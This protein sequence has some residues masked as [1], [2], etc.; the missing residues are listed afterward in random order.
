MSRPVTIFDIGDLSDTVKI[1]GHSVSVRGLSLSDILRLFVKYPSIYEMFSRSR[2][3][4][5]DDDSSA[6]RRR[7]TEE[8]PNA[9]YELM[10]VA[11]GVEEDKIDESIALFAKL[12][13]SSQLTL[14]T[15]IYDLTFEDGIGPFVDQ[16]LAV[17]SRMMMAATSDAQSQPASQK[18]S[19]SVSPGALQLDIPPRRS[20]GTRQGK[21]GLTAH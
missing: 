12:P 16:I 18:S 19:P 6:F 5:I 21:S 3:T 7:L 10:G 4:P 14:F 9:V 17:Q 2:E 15:K 11:T 1:R 13:A 20:G 8:A